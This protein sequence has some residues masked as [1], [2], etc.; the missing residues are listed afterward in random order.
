M[1]VRPHIGGIYAYHVFSLSLSLTIHDYNVSIGRSVCSSVDRFI[2]VFLTNVRAVGPACCE[3]FV[4]KGEYPSLTILGVF[5]CR[6]IAAKKVVAGGGG[7]REGSGG[8]DPARHPLRLQG[9]GM[10]TYLRR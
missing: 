9:T 4:F 6:R 8:E 7:D 10:H 5:V 1:S 3:R 2:M